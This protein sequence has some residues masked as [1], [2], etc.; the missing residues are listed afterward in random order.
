MDDDAERGVIFMLGLALG[1]LAMW[2]IF[3]TRGRQTARQA[4]EAAGD[5]AGDLAEGAEDVAEDVAEQAGQTA[6]LLRRRFG[7]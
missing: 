5:L 6:G 7:R 2:L 1:L 4:F 3:T